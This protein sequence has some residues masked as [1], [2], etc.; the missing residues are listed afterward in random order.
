M[1]GCQ[2]FGR[3]AHLITA[4]RGKRRDQPVAYLLLCMVRRSAVTWNTRLFSGS[5]T[6]NSGLSLPVSLQPEM[7][8]SCCQRSV[9]ARCCRFA[10]CFKMQ[11]QCGQ[12]QRTCNRL[13]ADCVG[14]LPQTLS[15]SRP[16]LPSQSHSNQC[17]PEVVHEQADYFPPSGLR[18]L[19][20]CTAHQPWQ[21]MSKK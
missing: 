1:Q 16:L 13:A 21:M 15:V 4:T 3:S 18:G 14:H 7:H 17:P 19:P 12:A 9:A 8:G 5:G 6:Q 10:G 11:Q 2:H 20:D